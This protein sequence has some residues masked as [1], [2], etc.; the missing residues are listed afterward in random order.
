MKMRRSPLI[1]NLYTD[2]ACR[3]NPGPGSWAA[4][5]EDSK[6]DL[7]FEASGVEMA[8]T[9]NKMELL[10]VNF[11]LLKLKEELKGTIEAKSIEVKIFS[12][13]QY[14]VKGISEWFSSWKKRGFKTAS[15]ERP[16]NLEEFIQLSELLSQF[17]RVHFAWVRGHAGHPQ[18]ERADQLC[19]LA[20]DDL[21][22]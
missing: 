12:D 4:V 7:L 13:S 15:G 17:K 9:N 22:I 1:F 20:L 14:V 3:G 18:N 11:G 5:G 19:N 2:G 16:K 8:T 10:A 21:K 6:G